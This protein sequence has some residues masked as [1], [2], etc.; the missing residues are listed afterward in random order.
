MLYVIKVT[1]RIGNNFK[2]V[3]GLK[4]SLQYYWKNVASKY[5]LAG[6][7]VEVYKNGRPVAI[8]GRRYG[9]A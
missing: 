2:H 7:Q 5:D 3:F 6:F 9:R 4:E 8:Y 1:T